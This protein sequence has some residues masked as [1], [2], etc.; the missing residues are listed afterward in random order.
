MH[1]LYP[2]SKSFTLNPRAPPPL[3][4]RSELSISSASVASWSSRSACGFSA[5][6]V[7]ANEP[8]LCDEPGAATGPVLGGNGLVKCADGVAWAL[9]AGEARMEGERVD[10]MV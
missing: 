1:A 7:S 4:R 10:E 8:A 2:L 6:D 5:G 9:K 3:H